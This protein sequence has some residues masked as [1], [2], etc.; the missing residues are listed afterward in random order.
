MAVAGLVTAA[1]GPRQPRVR[2]TIGEKYTTLRIHSI[3][4]FTWVN[5]MKI[6]MLPARFGDSFWITINHDGR[7]HRILIDGGTAGTRNTIH[8]L[9]RDLPDDD[10]RIDLMVVTH[11]DNDHIAGIL[12]MLQR[13]EVS[14]EV[15]D[16]WFNGRKH[17]PED[18][19]DFLGI[20]QGEQLGD[21]L[22]AADIPWNKAFG[23]EAVVVPDSGPLPVIELPGEI[24]LT[25]LSPTTEA[26]RKLA[27]VWEAELRAAQLLSSDTRLMDRE[28]DDE[29]VVDDGFLSGNLPDVRALAETDFEKDRSA[30]NGSSIAFLLEADGQRV[31]FAADAHVDTLLQGFER[32]SPG[33]KLEL[34]LFKISHH[35]S[36][37]TT[38]LDLI[39]QVDCRNYAVTTN[40]SIFKH[41]DTEA[42]SRV[43][44]AGG[45]D[46]QLLFNYRSMHN[47]VWENAALQSEFGY[48]TQYPDSNDH[49]LTIEL[50]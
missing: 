41:P 21:A 26:L 19:T 37:G 14:V 18:G 47:Q 44:M 8:R 6:Q 7:E 45:D 9:I 36:Q 22:A 42:I 20:D 32:L 28:D 33:Q 30:A 46:V 31:L 13:Q 1:G 29:D 25:L 2:G 27:R 15:A 48:R 39:E 11:V 12:T 50:N 3:V 34:D 23:G 5:P 10:R 35:G 16:F 43:L 49:G 38:S 40:G 4:R 24:R 17:L